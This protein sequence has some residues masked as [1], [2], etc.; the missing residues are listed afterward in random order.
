MRR[1]MSCLC[2]SGKRYEDCCQPYHEGTTH[3]PTALALMRS[4]YAAYALGKIDYIMKTTHR[5]YRKNVYGKLQRFCENTQ[6]EGLE[7]IE[8]LPGVREAFV[9]FKATL[10]QDGKDC[11]FIEKSRFLLEKGKWYYCCSL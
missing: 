4:R 6:F 10:S 7:I 11:S 3:A 2:H 1:S 5:A 9:T 8:D